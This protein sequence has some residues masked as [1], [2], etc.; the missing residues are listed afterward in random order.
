[1]YDPNKSTKAW[2]HEVLE[3]LNSNNERI[4]VLVVFGSDGVSIRLIE[5]F[6]NREWTTR[7]N[8]AGLKGADSEGWLHWSK[9][10]PGVRRA[11]VKRFWNAI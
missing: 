2:P 10:S 7:H 1:M 4:K 11:I 5:F 9:I 8:A 6:E 3:C